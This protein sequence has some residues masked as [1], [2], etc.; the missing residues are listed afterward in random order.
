MAESRHSRVYTKQR[1]EPAM[2]AA[3]SLDPPMDRGL[4]PFSDEVA[5]LARVREGAAG[6]PGLSTVV[7][8]AEAGSLGQV[9]VAAS[10]V[11][12]AS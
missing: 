11:K 3:L 9:T 8:L 6:L 2:S 5:G 7:S 1:L 4:A 12:T 10:L